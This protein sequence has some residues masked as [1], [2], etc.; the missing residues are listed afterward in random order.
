MNWLAAYSRLFSILD[1]SGTEAYHS[2]PSFI[3]VI[4][5][6]DAGQADYTLYLDDRNRK[7]LS[8]SRKDFYWDILQELDESLRYDVYRTFIDIVSP[9]FP[10]EADELKQYIYGSGNPVPKVKV[11]SNNWNSGKLNETIN[12]IDNA[13]DLSQYNHAMTLSYTCLEGLYKTYVH[14]N[15]SQRTNVT[16]LL[17]LS[18]L[19]RDDIEQQLKQT[20]PYPDMMVKSISTLTNAIANSRNGFSDSHFDQDSYKWLASYNRDLVNSIGRLILHFL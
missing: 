17:P 7:G 18:K 11:P 19:V 1:K 6:F 2:G 9:Y 15:I 4:K 20:G 12:K 5:Q 14:K 16:D 3:K 8:S 13:I 10:K